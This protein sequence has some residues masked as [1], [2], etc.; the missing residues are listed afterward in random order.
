MLL[1]LHHH[2]VCIDWVDWAWCVDLICLSWDWIRC[3]V[4]IV[5][6]KTMAIAIECILDSG[7][8]FQATVL[9]FKYIGLIDAVV[10]DL[11]C[12]SSCLVCS[13]DHA[14]LSSTLVQRAAYWWVLQHVNFRLELFHFRQVNAFIFLLFFVFL[15][16][17]LFV[18]FILLFITTWLAWAIRRAWWLAW[19]GRWSICLVLRLSI[20]H[21]SK[22]NA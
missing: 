11:S 4:D 13:Q 3:V 10:I 9:R 15:L 1:L 18:F 22:C 8:I 5:L 17:F 21:T 20:K 2:L 16:L 14:Y 6:Q 19:W 7:F 12:W